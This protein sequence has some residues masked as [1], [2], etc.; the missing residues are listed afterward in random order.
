VTKKLFEVKPDEKWFK[1]N[2]YELFT[3]DSN[4]YG[5]VWKETKTG[6]LLIVSKASNYYT[7]FFP[8]TGEFRQYPADYKGEKGYEWSKYGVDKAI[9]AA[10]SQFPQWGTT[11]QV[12]EVY[13][14]GK[15]AWGVTWQKAGENLTAWIKKDAI[16][17]GDV[18]W[19][20]D[21]F[22]K[23]PVYA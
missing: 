1:T 18:T 3:K 15:D 20:V 17:K 6:E 2:G 19:I 23:S 9:R 10:F 7:I 5:E 12:A 21:Q 16:I 4:G 13:D 11:F 14:T 8:T 22:A